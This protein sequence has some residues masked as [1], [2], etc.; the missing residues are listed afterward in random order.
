MKEEIKANIIRLVE[1]S[2][3]GFKGYQKPVTIKFSEVTE[4][5]GGNGLGKTTIGEAVVW[6]FFG[7]NITGNTKVDSHLM[8][9]LS[10][11]MCVEI[12]FK[13][14]DEIIHTLI[15]KKSKTTS[16]NLDGHAIKD[17][18]ILNM[19]DKDIF[20]SIYN[21]QYFL[22]LKEDKARELISRYLPKVSTEE[23]IKEIGE[24]VKEYLKDIRTD[25]IEMELEEKRS[26]LKKLDD[27]KIYLEGLRDGLNLNPEIPNLKEFDIKSLELLEEQLDSINK[28]AIDTSELT[29][30]MNKKSLLERQKFQLENSLREINNRKLELVET[31]TFEIRLENL[32]ERY[33]D[34]KSQLVKVSS[35]KC[36]VCGQELPEHIKKELKKE[37]IELTNQLKE[38][39]LNGK[40]LGQELNNIINKNKKKEEEFKSKNISD[41]TDYESNLGK[42]KFELENINK[43][44]TQ[45][46]Q[47]KTDNSKKNEIKSK[48]AVLKC[49]HDSINKNNTIHQ[50][51]VKKLEE[52]KSKFKNYE[53]KI[54]N[55]DKKKIY[56]QNQIQIIKSIIAKKSEINTRNIQ[57]F[58]NKTTIQI[59]KILKTGEVKDCFEVI[60]DGKEKVL[61]STSEAIRAGLEIADMFRK[62]VGVNYPTFID[63]KESITNYS[64]TSI[65]VIE[66]TVAPEKRLSIRHK[67]KENAVETA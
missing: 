7:S 15:R 30:I 34:K 51:L 14:D 64:T 19:L 13:T 36:S 52:D 2:I 31:A 8:N 33:A 55:I 39:E 61:L 48:I 50:T 60:Y 58:L 62:I 21:P 10:T 44:I 16:L 66:A 53:D 28:K 29:N 47:C 49:E 38:I 27:D 65:Q 3:I 56:I 41:K 26:M 5:Y 4:I 46:Q 22:N 18:D 40:K 17:S 9:N 54:A 57:M 6:C 20:L 43:K 11:K 59:Q 12:K 67:K 25:R 1:M 24:Y 45:L 63:C 35:N 32:R 23:A 37:S 42:V